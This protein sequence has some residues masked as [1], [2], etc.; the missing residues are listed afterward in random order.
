MSATVCRPVIS[1]RS[2]LGPNVTLTLQDSPVLLSP[3]QAAVEAWQPSQAQSEV[4]LHM[5]E[6]E[7]APS[8]ALERLQGQA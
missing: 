1:R 8:A 7:R 5:I 3:C 6:E 4:N 2:S